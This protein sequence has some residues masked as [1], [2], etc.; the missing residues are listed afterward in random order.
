LD[1]QVKAEPNLSD[2]AASADDI[3][4]SL[5][6][7]PTNRNVDRVLACLGLLDDAAPLFA[8]TVQVSSVGVLLAL[9][10]LVN[11]GVFEV[12]QRTYGTLGPAFYGLRTTILALLMMAL[13]RIKHIESLKEHSPRAL[14]RVLGLDRAP[15][16]K[17]LRRKLSRLATFGLASEFGRALAER[18][19]ATRGYAMGFLY[20]DGHV[21]AYHGKRQLPKTHLARMRLAMPATTDYWVNDAEGEPLFVVTTEANQG[22]VKMLP[23]VLDEVRSL[24]GD[25]RV[26]VVFDRGGN[27]DSL[28]MPSW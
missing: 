7:D 21:R 1:A 6:T 10:A 28:L 24:V 15:E 18:R 16:V 14:G 20:V 9:P 4:V 17:T 3:V 26:T 8:D 2:L 5:D 12:A 19:V 22:L 11:S 27:A 13:L 23:I 25:R